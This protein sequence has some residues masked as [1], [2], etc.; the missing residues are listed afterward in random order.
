MN[1]SIP[2]VRVL[3]CVGILL[4]AAQAFAQRGGGGGGAQNPPLAS[5]KTV[6]AP[7]STG[8]DRYVLDQTALI[9]LGKALF[10]DM[11][12]GSDGRTACATCHFHA[13]ADHR[14]QNQLSGRDAVINQVLASVD[15]P[16]HKLS[17]TGNNR[18][19]VVSDKQQVTGSMGVV[20]QGFVQV[21]PGTDTEISSSVAF[22]SPFMPNGVHVRQVTTRNASSVINA[23][24]NV[25][26]FWD[27]RASNVFTGTTPFGDSDS[28]LHALAYRNGNL[29]REAVRIE[30]ASLASQAVGPILSSVEM[31]WAGRA[32]TALGRKLLSLP[33]LARQKVSPTD[34]VL[35]TKANPD[36][37]GFTSEWSYTALIQ[38]AFRPEYYN[39]PDLFEGYTQM[40]NNFGLFWGLA[41]QAYES[42]L[43]ANDS[44][45]DQFLE[46]RTGVLTA[47]EQ[48][49]LNQ[50]R[51]G[52]SQCTNCHNGAE[53]TAAGWSVVQRRAGNIGVAANAGF[54]RIGVRPIAEDIGFGGSDDFGLP[55]FSAAPAS[56]AGTFKAPGLRNVE[57][58]GPYFHNGSQATLEQ[59]LDFY[60]RNG[61]FPQDGNLG[62]GIG[63]IRLN[64]GERT[65]I[66]AFLKAL[67]DDRVRFQ[68]APF[69]H[70]SLCVPNGHV[71]SSG[72]L[73]TDPAQSGSVALDK[74]A[75]VPE[76]G[77]EGSSVPLQ[78]FDELLKGIGNDG[79]RANTMTTA[80]TP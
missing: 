4:T 56:A 14:V 71:E 63:N 66:V 64:Q 25:R 65:A 57:F 80:C 68:R 53:F 43:I 54:F 20:A 12:A 70:P 47:L 76:A 32:W 59:V 26:N 33:P 46:G 30:N 73:E 3:L 48:Q 21:E 36:G 44:R 49:G 22:A 34:S 23:V 42:T 24:Y 7:L 67:S 72:Q 69:D 11:Q 77:S 10:W 19:A 38:A 62:P 40:E 27:G 50:F 52:D 35:G 58:T 45:V 13:G 74:W 61:D 29:Q 17:N 31:S 9:V 39:S 18:S 60:G 2:S 8:L 6:A 75:L 16:F 1:A 78:T 55:L 41:I 37:N 28:G 51:A 5:L 15:F 79:S